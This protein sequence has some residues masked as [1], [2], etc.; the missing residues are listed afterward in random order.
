MISTERGKHYIGGKIRGL[1]LPK[2]VFP[3]VTPAELRATLPERT[4]RRSERGG[5]A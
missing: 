5:Y 1:A 3:C 4:V 2:R